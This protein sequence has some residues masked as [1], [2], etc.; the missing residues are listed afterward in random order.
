MEEQ[1]RL[2][3]EFRRQQGEEAYLTEQ[4]MDQNVGEEARA[5]QEEEEL[6]ERLKRLPTTARRRTLDMFRGELSDDS[7][8]PMF[9][10]RR[11]V[12]NM[13]DA[14][15]AT[16]RD[17]IYRPSGGTAG[18]Q[19]DYDQ[20]QGSQQVGESRKA[21]IY[22]DTQV[23]KLKL[24]S[25]KQKPANG[26][27]DYRHWKRA[28]IRVRDDEDVSLSKRKKIIMDSL[29]GKADDLIDLYR[30]TSIN[31]IM[32]VL[33]ANFKM[34]V[35]GE[36]LLADF[37]QMVQ[38]EKKAASEF[39][40]DLY[41]ELIEVVKEEGAQLGQMPRLLLK[42]FLRGCRDDDLILTLGLRNKLQNPPHFPFLMAE[43]RRE[44]ARKT[45]RRLRLKKSTAARAQAATVCESTDMCDL[46]KKVE[47]LEM[48]ATNVQMIPNVQSEMQD[49]GLN[50]QEENPSIAQLQRRMA[51]L[52][53]KLSKVGDPFF[54]YKCGIDNHIAT[55]C[56]NVP[57][58]SLVNLKMEQ[59]KAKS[60]EQ[61]SKN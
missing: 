30:D 19:P 32:E 44:E 17:T 58:K 57:N 38:D 46:H 15:R 22:V 1:D 37:Y 60:Q 36:D 35:D 11:P 4:M 7:Q 27:L 12:F 16:R 2:L 50:E 54:C 28:A 23:K 6:Y 8:F 43:I 59:R 61:T 21:N 20:I 47:Q 52:E 53:E 34:M 24:F 31:N 5:L 33:D 56:K 41:I 40:S 49:G 10:D 45:E 14:E 39:L 3:E 13:S 26:E 29:Q 18:Y 55:H 42:Q 51:Q 48:M 9:Q 25:G